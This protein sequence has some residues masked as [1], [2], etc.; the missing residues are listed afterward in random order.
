[1]PRDRR[2]KPIVDAILDDSESAATLAD[3]SKRVGAS[4]RTIQRIFVSET[5]LHFSIWK[6]QAILLEALR[7]LSDGESVL[8]V[9]LDL[10]YVSPSAFTHMFRQAFGVTPSRFFE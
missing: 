4:E 2:V 5:G 8:N 6:R 9:A 10:G 1:M 7:K 3:W